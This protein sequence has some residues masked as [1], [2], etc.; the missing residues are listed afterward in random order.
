MKVIMKTANPNQT[1][2]LNLERG[3]VFRLLKG[4]KPIIKTNTRGHETDDCHAG[5]YL[6]SGA[7]TTI[8]YNAKVIRLKATVTVEEENACP[9]F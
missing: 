9:K 1:S 7:Y 2:Y 8:K 6:E 4:D 3:D 5:V